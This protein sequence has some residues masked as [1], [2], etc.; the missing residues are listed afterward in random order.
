VCD[1]PFFVLVLCAH[2]GCVYVFEK[3]C[4]RRSIVLISGSEMTSLRGSFIRMS[5][6]ALDTASAV[7]P[8]TC[9]CVCVCVCVRVCVCVC[10]CV[11]V[12]VCVWKCDV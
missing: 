6:I 2:I 1:L 12:C 5:P 7:G 8:A 9:V 10:A 3:T 11:C 4:G